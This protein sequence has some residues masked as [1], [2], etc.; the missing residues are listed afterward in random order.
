MPLKSKKSSKKHRLLLANA[1]AE[2]QAPISTTD[3]VK[4]RVLTH[5]YSMEINF[6]TK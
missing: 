4:S 5:V 1:E 3:T 2:I 6:V